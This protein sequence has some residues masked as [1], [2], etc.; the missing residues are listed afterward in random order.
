MY[1]YDKEFE[2]EL[3]QTN[4]KDWLDLQVTKAK[5][6]VKNHPEVATV[7]A[8]VLPYGLKIAG[9]EYRSHR[10]DVRI[11]KELNAKERTFYDRS[12]NAYYVTKK[13][14]TTKQKTIIARRKRNGESYDV[15]LKSLGLL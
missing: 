7:A 10:K 4:K 15:I 5:Y 1:S 3:W 14:P 11:R 8:I 2:K 6:W 12:I 13:V 9:D